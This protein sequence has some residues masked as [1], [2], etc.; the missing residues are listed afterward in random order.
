MKWWF[1]SDLHI[2]HPF[3]VR[4]RG[5]H[6]MAHHDT[7]IINGW[8]DIVHPRDVVVVCGDVLWNTWQD[9]EKLWIGLKGTKILVK[10]N[11]DRWLKHYKIPFLPI[12]TLLQ[13]K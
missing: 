5:F 10:G 4:E 3:C 1:T 11:H 7:T 8:N 9:I 2:G 6:T 12:V 13:K